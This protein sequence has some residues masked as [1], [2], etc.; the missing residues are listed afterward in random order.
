MS[1][2]FLSPQQIATYDFW[3]DPNCV[4][5]PPTYGQRTLLAVS[6]KRSDFQE[7]NTSGVGLS[8]AF[9]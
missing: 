6:K 9:G 8:I 5:L 1:V 2:I 4:V 7:R 3:H